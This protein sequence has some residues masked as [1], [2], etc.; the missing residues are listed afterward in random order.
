MIPAMVEEKAAQ[1]RVNAEFGLWA[2]DVE[3]VGVRP[4]FQVVQWSSTTSLGIYKDVF[5]VKVIE[6]GEVWDEEP[7]PSRVRAL[8]QEISMMLM[9][10]EDC[11]FQPV[12]RVFL[13]GPLWLHCFF[14]RHHYARTSLL[15]L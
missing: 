15:F 14:G 2:L 10:G 8:K 12:G 7:E 6:N 1:D 3:K 11:S 13:R 9:A 5:F 4:H